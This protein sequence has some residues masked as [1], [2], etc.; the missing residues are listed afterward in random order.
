MLFISDRFPTMTVATTVGTITLPDDYAGRWFVL[1]SHPAD[2]TPVCTTE[3]VAFEKMEP[4][5]DEMNTEL[6]G[7]SV[8]QVFSH[9]KWIEWIREK[10]RV[11]ISFPIIA[12]ELGHV[13]KQ[14][15]MIHPTKGTRTVRSVYIVDHEGTIRLMLTYPESVGRNIYEIVRAVKTLQTADA[16]KAA[17]P[18]NWPHNELVGDRLIMPPPRTIQ[19]AE[20]RL[21]KAKQGEINCFDWW[22]CTKQA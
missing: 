16:Y 4:Q 9:M 14:L 8:E 3:F 10:L 21:N 7:L 19:Q 18:A 5:F 1:F 20:E 17:T 13:A 11:R 12:D 2:F 22:F 15:G 6:I